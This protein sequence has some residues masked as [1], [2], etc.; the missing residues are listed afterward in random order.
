[1]VDVLVFLHSFLAIVF[2]VSGVAKLL[3]RHSFYDTLLEIGL[4]E[5]SS[6]KTVSWLFPLAEIVVA[7]LLLIERTRLTGAIMILAML[8]L[9]VMISIRALATKEKKINCQCFGN[10]VEESLGASTLIRSAVLFLCVIPLLLHREETG[11]YQLSGLEM[12]FAFLFSIGIIALYALL[13]AYWN[14]YRL[15]KGGDFQ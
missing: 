6:A 8:I 9:F 15:N 3:S 5:N 13:T 1:M 14:R 11:L 10:L 4:K 2:L 7:V 12:E